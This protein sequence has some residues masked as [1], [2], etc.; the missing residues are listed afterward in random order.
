MFGRIEKKVPLSNDLGNTMK[1]FTIEEHL[2]SMLEASPETWLVELAK[3][4]QE[5][6]DLDHALAASQAFDLSRNL[7]AAQG[8]KELIQGYHTIQHELKGN[9][10]TLNQQHTIRISLHA[11]GQNIIKLA[12]QQG[13]NTTN[14][15]SNEQGEKNS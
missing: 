10:L 7:L 4:L 13:N 1:Q 6:G 14:F 15:Q 3:L 2:E 5:L 12:R 8:L 11:L 9:K